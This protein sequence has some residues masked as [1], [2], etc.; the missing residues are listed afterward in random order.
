[1]HVPESEAPVEN[2]SAPTIA[3]EQASVPVDVPASESAA[4]PAEAQ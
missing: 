1:M 4:V 3:T 2:E